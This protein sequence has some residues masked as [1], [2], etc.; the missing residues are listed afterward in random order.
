MSVPT[1]IPNTLVYFWPVYSASFVLDIPFSFKAI[2]NTNWCWLVLYTQTHIHVR[3]SMYMYWL[4]TMAW[5]TAYITYL[6]LSMTFV[7]VL[8]FAINSRWLCASAQILSPLHT[9]TLTLTFH[10]SLYIY[11]FGSLFPSFPPPI[12]IR[13]ATSAV[14]LV[15]VVPTTWTWII[16]VGICMRCQRKKCSVF[17]TARL[18][19]VKT[20]LEHFFI[21]FDFERPKKIFLSVCPRLRVPVY[22]C[23]KWNWF[24]KVLHLVFPFFLINKSPIAS[25]LWVI[26]VGD[27][28][29]Q[30]N[31]ELKVPKPKIKW[32][33]L[34]MCYNSQYSIK[35]FGPLVMFLSALWMREKEAPKPKWKHLILHEL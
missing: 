23:W 9:H 16:Y 19:S 10:F 2:C 8:V 11:S 15:L 6:Y 32:E 12:A 5:C 30:P 14:V 1:P 33:N 21:H 25:N 3:V 29:R 4:I 7:T 34:E 22:L 26:W 24:Y 35:T 31:G 13:C 17:T 18:C 28:V 20:F 27:K